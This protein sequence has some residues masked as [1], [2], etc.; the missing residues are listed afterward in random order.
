MDSLRFGIKLPYKSND[1][2]KKECYMYAVTTKSKKENKSIAVAN[3]VPQHKSGK[4][5]AIL[6]NRPEMI[7]QAN[8]ELMIN[9]SPLTADKSGQM[10]RIFGKGAPENNQL[11][12]MGPS[13]YIRVIQLNGKYDKEIKDFNK[14]KE[15]SKQ[16]RDP[17]KPV[18]KKLRESGF[19]KDEISMPGSRADFI[20]E[21]SDKLALIEVK[22]DSGKWTK[23]DN[24]NFKSGSHV[25]A[26]QIH[27]SLS[28]KNSKLKTLF[29]KKTSELFEK[30]ELNVAVTNLS[31]TDAM[32]ALVLDKDNKIVEQHPVTVSQIIAFIEDNKGD[33]Y[34]DLFEK[35]YD[36]ENENKSNF[37]EDFLMDVY[38]TGYPEDIEDAMETY[39]TDWM[40]SKQE[41]AIENMDAI[42]ALYNA[43]RIDNKHEI[44][45]TSG[46]K[47]N[48]RAVD[49]LGSL[50]DY[51][52]KGLLHIRLV[53]VSNRI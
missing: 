8:L 39:V 25:P 14:G 30:K 19:E 40:A 44:S 52:D 53:P 50:N 16:I 43:A 10:K 37:Y 48:P 45:N 34:L 15:K 13:P 4:Q 6:D 49:S 5:P 46:G 38:T 17:E 47:N 24:L 51:H 1:S 2:L 42:E 36:D 18:Y 3:S 32:M 9:N 22:G 26:R 35:L 27:Q 31:D 29:E 28:S 21:N 41:R 11:K 12:Q 33:S 20:A 23:D 7:D